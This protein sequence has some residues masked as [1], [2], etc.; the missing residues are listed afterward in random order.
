MRVIARYKVMLTKSSSFDVDPEEGVV[1]C[2]NQPASPGDCKA[3]CKKLTKHFEALLAS[4]APLN[5]DLA[6]FA[7]KALEHT[8]YEWVPRNE[9]GV[10][11]CELKARIPLDTVA[12]A[13]AAAAKRPAARSRRGSKP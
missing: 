3:C 7:R 9:N 11:S 10:C 13:S 4:E 5:D 1:V 2:S 6:K 12:V 8:D